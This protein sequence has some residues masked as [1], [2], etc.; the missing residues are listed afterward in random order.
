MLN[1]SMTSPASP[2]CQAEALNRQ[3]LAGWEAHLGA[4]HPDTLTSMNNLANL[5]QQQGKLAEDGLRS[6]VKRGDLP[7]GCFSGAYFLCG[8]GLRPGFFLFDF[9]ILV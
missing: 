5:L 4:N 3:V 9:P 6:F 1:E 2:R 7:G 8:Q